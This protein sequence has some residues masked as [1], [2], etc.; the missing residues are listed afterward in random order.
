LT[1]LEFFEAIIL[2]LLIVTSTTEIFLVT[3]VASM[4]PIS[5]SSLSSPFDAGK[6]KP[7]SLAVSTTSPLVLISAFSSPLLLPECL[8][9]G[10]PSSP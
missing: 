1:D 5:L 9:Q 6:T 4:I 7:I 2:L 3:L 10:G 8:F